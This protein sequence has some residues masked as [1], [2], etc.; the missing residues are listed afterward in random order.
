MSALNNIIIIYSFVSIYKDTNDG[1]NDSLMH[2]HSES[3][4]YPEK[5]ADSEGINSGLQSKCRAYKTHPL[6][7]VIYSHGA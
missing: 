3:A 4:L 7:E 5:S 1:A 6:R 2:L